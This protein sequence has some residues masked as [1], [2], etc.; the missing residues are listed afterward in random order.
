MAIGFLE[1]AVGEP[2]CSL[3]PV[4]FETVERGEKY[5]KSLLH[6]EQLRAIRKQ[7]SFY[8]GLVIHPRQQF[9]RLS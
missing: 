5:S 4:H 8:A 9:E 7:V 6:T 2:L 1:Y 3:K